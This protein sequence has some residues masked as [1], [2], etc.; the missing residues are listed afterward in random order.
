MTSYSAGASAAAGPNI[1]T[2]IAFESGLGASG[3][4]PSRVYV[5]SASGA[6]FEIN[7]HR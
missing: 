4:G 3:G 2:D 7:Y 1:F 6:L 5:A